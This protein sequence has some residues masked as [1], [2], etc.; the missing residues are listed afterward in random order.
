MAS[1]DYKRRVATNIRLIE[2]DEQERG[3]I[4]ILIKEDS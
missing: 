4:L 1:L 2:I 3:E